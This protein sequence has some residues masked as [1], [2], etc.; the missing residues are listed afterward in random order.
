[1]MKVKYLEI[2]MDKV[3][4]EDPATQE[5]LLKRAGLSLELSND[6]Y[7]SDLLRLE[8]FQEIR[9]SFA[10]LY[11]NEHCKNSGFQLSSNLD[12]FE[13]MT[14][15]LLPD[16]TLCVF[17]SEVYCIAT[18]PGRLQVS[19]ANLNSMIS[20]K[21]VRINSVEIYSGNGF[22]Y[23]A[24][25]L[26]KFFLQSFLNI[27]E[28][29]SA[30]KFESFKESAREELAGF[31]YKRCKISP[32]SL[33][34]KLTEA[35]DVLKAFGEEDNFEEN[36]FLEER[37]GFEGKFEEEEE[38]DE[39]NEEGIEFKNSKAPIVELQQIEEEGSEE[40][41]ENEK[42]LQVF[43]FKPALKPF[44]ELL[45]NHIER[46]SLESLEYTQSEDTGRAET[47]FR[48]SN[49]I[50]GRFPRLSGSSLAV[51]ETP[52][53]DAKKSYTE[54][55]ECM[56]SPRFSSKYHSPLKVISSTPVFS[57]KQAIYTIQ[58]V[59]DFLL[60]RESEKESPFG[61]E[62]QKKQ[63]TSK[64]KPLS[65]Q[66]TDSKSLNSELCLSS[67]EY[68]KQRTVFEEQKISCRCQSCGIF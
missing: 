14:I 16:W 67:R 65:F 28:I 24:V 39:R 50:T 36:S 17:L 49:T 15:A 18:Q 41:G 7:L 57:P 25:N 53:K 6:I 8:Y 37:S 44:C 22:S 45:V 20:L 23:I 42:F 4:I 2:I 64:L 55:I 1:M 62:N 30:D 46:Y 38:G 61:K 12:H 34:I 58:E 19:R 54:Y 59:K 60:A 47:S 35:K 27:E 21:D 11:L 31:V 51:V 66:D 26:C 29:L 5:D 63:R 9:H 52:S 3:L 32:K 68:T 13:R 56:E 10:L 48:L 43:E 33:L 40:F